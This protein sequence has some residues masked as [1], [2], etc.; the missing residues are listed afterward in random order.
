MGGA[1]AA[2]LGI[3]LKEVVD[4]EVHENATPVGADRK[5]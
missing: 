2:R 1:R 4:Q 5:R 3:S